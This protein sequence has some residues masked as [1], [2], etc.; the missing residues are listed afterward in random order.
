MS[1]NT[2]DLELVAIREFDQMPV[3]VNAETL[4]LAREFA[5]RLRG[6][7]ALWGPKEQARV[8]LVFDGYGL[9]TG[10]A[11]TNK[12][13]G[14][15]HGINSDLASAKRLEGE[16]LLRATLGH[17]EDDLA[18]VAGLRDL[19]LKEVFKQL[20]DFVDADLADRFIDAS[21]VEAFEIDNETREM[22]L[23]AYYANHLGIKSAVL[24]GIINRNLGSIPS[25]SP[26]GRYYAKGQKVGLVYDKKL[27]DHFL[28]AHYERSVVNIIHHYEF[29][30]RERNLLQ[31][32]VEEIMAG[33][34]DRSS[35]EQFVALMKGRNFK[36]YLCK[37]WFQ[38]LGVWHLLSS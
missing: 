3:E 7:L 30:L 36:F 31:Q 28:R 37:T 27:V 5:E 32:M 14:D 12:E 9:E 17:L 18:A 23:P 20:A 34:G 11:L 16:V 15:L 35:Q 33:D 1:E 19:I 2:K 4:M 21:G 26:Q 29:S 22:I 6:E 10:Q 25:F 38:R 24:L 8:A 13:L